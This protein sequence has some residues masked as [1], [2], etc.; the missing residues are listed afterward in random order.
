[1]AQ[2]FAP[3]GSER[4]PERRMNSAAG[5]CVI[6]HTST[7]ENDDLLRFDCHYITLD[8]YEVGYIM[9]STAIIIPQA[10]MCSS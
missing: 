4:R 6:R 3:Q 1:M 2:M 9:F 8:R 7:R 10:T 5:R